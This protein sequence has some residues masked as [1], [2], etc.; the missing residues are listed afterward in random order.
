MIFDQCLTF[1]LLQYLDDACFLIRSLLNNAF[2]Y[3]VLFQPTILSNIQTQE[4]RGHP[5]GAYAKVSKKLT[6][7]T[8]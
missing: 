5:F 2:K 7:L 3:K 4:P 8:P 6:F 1:R